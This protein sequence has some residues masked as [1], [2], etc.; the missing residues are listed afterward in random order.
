MPYVLKA[1]VD[2]ATLGEVS[3]VWRSLFGEQPASRA[4]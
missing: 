3:D 1:L 2:G 4:F